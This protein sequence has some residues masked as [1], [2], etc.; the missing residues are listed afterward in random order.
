M[1]ALTRYAEDRARY[2]VAPLV[3]LRRDLAYDP[4]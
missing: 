1:N 4:R 3:R 2:W